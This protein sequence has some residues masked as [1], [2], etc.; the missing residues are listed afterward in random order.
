[1][2][3]GMLNRCFSAKPR[4]KDPWIF[5]EDRGLAPPFAAM[6]RNNTFDTHDNGGRMFRVELLGDFVH[7]W[8]LTYD[9]DTGDHR[10][11]GPMVWYAHRPSRVF[12]GRSPKNAFTEF[13]G[14]HGDRFYGNSVLVEFPTPDDDGFRYALIGR[15]ITRIDVPDGARVEIFMSPVGNNDVPYPYAVDSLGRTH[16]FLENV[17]LDPAAADEYGD[18]PYTY[19]Y[20]VGRIPPRKPIV[21]RFDGI[22]RF[23]LG[24]EPC[25]MRYAPDAVAEYARITS[26]FGQVEVSND[27]S[28]FPRRALNEADYVDLMRRFGK[29][30][31][32]SHLRT[33]EEVDAVDAVDEDDLREDSAPEKDQVVRMGGNAPPGPPFV[34]I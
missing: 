27:S 15:S 1:M 22:N 30:A 29:V 20:D 32:F 33:A 18:D 26:R 5:P 34:R 6:I 11:D 2:V 17:T 19:Y 7:V 10:V 3:F 23:F 12:P 31:G 13:G 14:G 25:T 9:E 4:E 8:R 21:D 28:G 16:L 24:G